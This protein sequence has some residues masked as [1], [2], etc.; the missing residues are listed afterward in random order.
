VHRSRAVTEET[1]GQR[2]VGEHG[3][4][5]AEWILVGVCGVMDGSSGLLPVSPA[6]KNLLNIIHIHHLV[7]LIVTVHTSV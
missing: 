2:A 7:I 3:V 1:F 6:A 5:A 4:L